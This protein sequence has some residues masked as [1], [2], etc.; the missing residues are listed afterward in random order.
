MA[1][2]Y[3]R[4]SSDI[5]IPCP[6]LWH[7]LSFVTAS[8]VLCCGI[9]RPIRSIDILAL[10]DLLIPDQRDL[11]KAWKA[12]VANHIVHEMDILFTQ[13]IPMFCDEHQQQLNELLNKAQF[14]TIL[15]LGSA[16]F[17]ISSFCAMSPF[18]G[19]LCYAYHHYLLI[20]GPLTFTVCAL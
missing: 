14:V 16:L 20:L 6:L 9:P 8:L 7:P 5:P 11:W 10:L 4:C 15:F 19:S 3:A 17:L 18:L 1:I 12:R 2:Q 13:T